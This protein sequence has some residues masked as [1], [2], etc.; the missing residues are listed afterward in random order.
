M[1]ADA[2]AG[3]R[4]VLARVVEANERWERLA[5][6]LRAENV[7]LR[8]ETERLRADVERLSAELAVLQ[9]LVF[10]RSSERVRP[11]PTAG[12]DDDGD[13]RGGYGEGPGG[14]QPEKVSPRG[15]GGR[16]GRRDY[17]HLPRVE[18][19]WDFAEG[20]YC[21]PQCSSPFE[22]FDDHAAEQVDWRVMVRVVVHRR[23]RYRRRCRCAGPRTVTAPGPP[24]AIGKGRFS[25]G[26]IAML[27][28]ER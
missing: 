8:A 6:Q 3:L 2:D 23:R 25:N 27:L 14:Q 5:G 13:D 21:C 11:Q 4:D 22:A 9:R 20:G 15:P 7:E 1:E 17:S 18:V 24:K 28:V 16:A 10:G 12:D 19:F 26:F